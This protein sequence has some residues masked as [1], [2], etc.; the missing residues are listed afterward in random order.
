MNKVRCF[1]LTSFSKRSL[2]IKDILR[3]AFSEI[4]IE[5]MH[6]TDMDSA[7]PLLEGMSEL[8]TK[9]EFL[10]ADISDLNP[11][12]L[13]EIGYAMGLGLPIVIIADH[14]T[15]IPVS[16]KYEPLYLV[17]YDKQK[18]LD[19][20][21]ALEILS[22]LEQSGRL[23]HK[24]EMKEQ[25]LPPRDQ[26]LLTN[27]F[28]FLS[29]ETTYP[30]ELL[31]KLFVAPPYFGIIC[32]PETAVLFGPRGCGKTMLLYMLRLRSSSANSQVAGFY[33]DF[34][35]TLRG[36]IEATQV[37]SN[38][39]KMIMY[40][41]LSL[42][43]AFAN[44]VGVVRR[45]GRISDEEENEILSV[46]EK[47]TNICVNSL[48]V[49][50]TTLNSFEQWELARDVY[51]WDST[52]RES[53]L[54]MSSIEN[55]LGN[56][57]FLENLAESLHEN[58]YAFSD[59]NVAYLVD[60]YSADWLPENVSHALNQIVFKRSPYYSFKVAT[61]L[62]R[63]MVWRLSSSSYAEP[64]RDYIPINMTDLYFSDLHSRARFLQEV[65]DSRL[66]LAGSRTPSKVLFGLRPK[67]KRVTADYS[68]IDGLAHLF[69]GDCAT[70]IGACARMTQNR[71]LDEPVPRESQNN[72][73]RTISVDIFQ[74]LRSGYQWGSYVYNFVRYMMEFARRFQSIEAKGLKKRKRVFSGFVF[75]DLTKFSSE[76][77]EKLSWLI[78]SGVLLPYSRPRERRYAVRKILFPAFGVPI[79]GKS[80]YS[81]MD[82]YDSEKMFNDPEG[83]WKMKIRTVA[84][85][86]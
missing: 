37:T 48:S 35:R 18:G 10:V 16:L 74:S 34:N 14:K 53:G 56:P 43:R 77:Q 31:E 65:L 6:A 21:Q 17:R 49:L 58:T 83:F 28:E 66:A 78:R 9:A 15:D 84:D 5:V 19:K 13:F 46:V 27:P 44:E 50:S 33:V 79:V 51:G 80:D 26:P 61:I 1:L 45:S 57:S 76:A 75:K 69:S 36:A 82:L 85:E 72:I 7:K 60:D 42:L 52:T 3:K 32:S 86:S 55:Q 30:P 81:V 62:G 11:N 64:Y 22:V 12:I 38:I 63:Q 40:F 23:R 2:Q 67:G 20:G 71:P 4:G 70:I 29:A 25:L 39:T 47:K 68:G 54:P 24:F 41:N 73:L 8:L 59:Y